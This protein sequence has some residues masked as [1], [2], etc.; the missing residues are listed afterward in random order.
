M[1]K[2]SKKLSPVFYNQKDVLFKEIVKIVKNIHARSILDIGA[3]DGSLATR[4]SRTVPTYIAVEKNRYFTERLLAENIRVIQGTFPFKIKG[5]FDLVLISHA[6]PEKK[7]E[8]RRFLLYAWKKVRKGGALLIITF[9]GQ[10]GWNTAFND[11]LKN[12][13]SDEA[14]YSHMLTILNKFGKV[15]TKKIKSILKSKNSDSIIKL[16]AGAR[17]FKKQQDQKLQRKLGKYKSMGVYI[18]PTTHNVLIVKK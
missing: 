18:V 2:I 17:K 3:G 11:L 15:Q 10:G 9:K 14:L 5:L 16:L 12:T 1:S 7:D 8:Y 4:I 13:I 6:I